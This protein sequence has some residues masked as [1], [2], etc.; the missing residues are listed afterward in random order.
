MSRQRPILAFED[1]DMIVPRDNDIILEFLPIPLELEGFSGCLCVVTE[2]ATRRRQA[3]KVDGGALSRAPSARTIARLMTIGRDNLSK[4]ETV[5]VAAIE[6]G[7]PL[8]V[9]ARE[10]IGAFQAM[11]RKKSL[12][13][14]GPW[15]ER[16]RSSLIA[17]FANGVSKDQAAVSAAITSPWSNGQTEGQI[18]KLKLV[19]CQM[20]GRGKLDL[21][22]ARVIGA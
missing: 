22:Q 16:A 1:E 13:D 15:W 12:T 20:Y 4:A 8:L 19:K 18:T 7:V 10:I 9:E 5:T 11:I 3:E 21:F 6:S 14:L 2:W 17:S